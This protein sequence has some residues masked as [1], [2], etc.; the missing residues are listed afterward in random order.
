[1][2][3]DGR[4]LVEIDLKRGLHHDMMKDVGPYSGLLRGA[5]DG[6]ISAIVGGPN[7]RSR[8]ILRHRP[9]EGRPD[10]PRPIRAW[11]GAEYGVNDLTES[12]WNIIYEDDIMLRRFG[13][14]SSWPRRF[15]RRWDA[16]KM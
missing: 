15:E 14:S 6:K 11:N 12:E 16:K 7:C 1:M 4:K 5:L 9:I 13:F 2:G 10:A 8:S 3:G